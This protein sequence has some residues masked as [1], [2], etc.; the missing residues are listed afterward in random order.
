MFPL[1][2]VLSTPGAMEAIPMEAIHAAL[3]RHAK[4]DWG[5]VCDEDRALND[6]ALKDGSRLLSVALIDHRSSENATGKQKKG[7]LHR[8]RSLSCRFPQSP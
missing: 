4:A 7:K 6:Q 2:Q 8:L 5:D 3:A 1:G